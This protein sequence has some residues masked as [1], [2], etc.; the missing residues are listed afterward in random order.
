MLSPCFNIYNFCFLCFVRQKKVFTVKIKKRL[1]SSGWLRLLLINHLSSCFGS[2]V[3]ATNWKDLAKEQIWFML[4][5]LQFSSVAW[6]NFKWYL[7]SQKLS[8]KWIFGHLAS[9]QGF[10]GIYIVIFAYMVRVRVPLIY[11]FW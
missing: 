4:S 11:P 5:S 8:Q 2:L 6:R 3:L 10:M 9:D 1:K 7:V